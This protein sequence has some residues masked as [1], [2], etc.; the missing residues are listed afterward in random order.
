MI[1]AAGSVP[2]DMG[3]DDGLF[4]HIEN[5]HMAL[6]ASYVYSASPLGL[7]G[8][9]ASVLAKNGLLTLELLFKPGS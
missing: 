3:Y 2:K 7:T 4:H 5:K 6:Q 9:L 1:V 8:S